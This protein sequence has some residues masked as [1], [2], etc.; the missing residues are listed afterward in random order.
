MARLTDHDKKT[1]LELSRRGWKQ[2]DEERSPI[3]VQPTPEA[4]ARYCQ[5]V[6]QISAIS[7]GP[8][9]VRFSGENWKL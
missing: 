3:F 9:E 4:N 8:R 7:E 5:W 2:S 1:F 6:S